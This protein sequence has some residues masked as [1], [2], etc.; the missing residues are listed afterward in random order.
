M[1]ESQAVQFGAQ[2]LEKSYHSNGGGFCTTRGI[3]R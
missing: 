1:V 2:A 3:Q